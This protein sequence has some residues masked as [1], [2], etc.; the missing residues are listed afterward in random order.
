MAIETEKE[1]GSP[2]S[3][4]RKNDVNIA[5]REFT[6]TNA[7]ILTTVLHNDHAQRY[8]PVASERSKVIN[9]PKSLLTSHNLEWLFRRK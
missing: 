9:T 7:N 6:N 3:E 2:I 8:I 5:G 4:A 1:K